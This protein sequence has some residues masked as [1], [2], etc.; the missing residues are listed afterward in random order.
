MSYASQ[1]DLEADI[2]LWINRTDLGG[3]IPSFVTL[4][5]RRIKGLTQG[6]QEVDM[7]DYPDVFLFGAL[8]EAASYLIDGE[9]AQAWNA[10][11]MD[12]LQNM[13]NYESKINPPAALRT[14]IPE[15]LSNRYDIGTD[16]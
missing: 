7:H 11:F 6:A 15:F 9:R 2:A 14:E 13:N 3:V 12:A 4:A 1:A 5:E 16:A 10:R 8:V